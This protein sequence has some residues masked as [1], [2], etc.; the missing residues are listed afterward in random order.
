M[1]RS[2]ASFLASGVAKTR[3]PELGAGAAGTEAGV[4]AEVGGG[5][6]G[7]GRAAAGGG[8]GVGS[9]GFGAGAGAAA[10][11]AEASSPALKFANAATSF[12]LATTIHNNF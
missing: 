11:G 2:A 7:G 5:G 9:A 6:G 4:G 10:F 3:P 8:G 1:F 12:L